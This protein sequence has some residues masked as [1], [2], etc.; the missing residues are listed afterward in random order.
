MRDERGDSLLDVCRD[1]GISLVAYGPLGHGLLTGAI[2]DVD[3]MDAS[4]FRHR[5]PRFQAGNIEHNAAL[6]AKVREIAADIDLSPPQVAIAWLLHQGDDVVPIVGT[7]SV[8]H[9]DSNLAAADV[10][11]DVATLERLNEAVPPGAVKG[12]QY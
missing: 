6:A 3:D 4:D 10:E 9:L 11:L 8:D 1:L 7:R 2:E 12:T 5:L